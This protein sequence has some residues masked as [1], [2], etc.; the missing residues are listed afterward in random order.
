MPKVAR[1]KKPSVRVSPMMEGIKWKGRGKH[2]CVLN[3]GVSCTG[4]H[5]ALQRA[6]WPKW[7]F[8]KAKANGTLAELPLPAPDKFIP[9]PPQA[10]DRKLPYSKMQGIRYDA[11]ITKTVKLSRRHGLP[12]VFW[13][14]QANRTLV[15][16]KLKGVTKSAMATQAR[17]RN[18]VKLLMPET[19]AFWSLMHHSKMVPI[20]TQTP[21]ACNKVGTKLDVLCTL[22]EQR[23]TYRVLEMKHGCEHN[24]SIRGLESLPLSIRG[25]ERRVTTHGQHLLQTWTNHV[26]FKAAFPERKTVDPWL[27]RVDRMGAHVYVAPEQAGVLMLL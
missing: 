7:D 20:E 19:L 16:N 6:Y 26:L 22:A 15:L 3:A 24:W 1:A 25:P 21:V 5:P 23:E 11:E 13:F 2:K 9:V 17:L 27:V 18:A 4:V 14:D 8:D 12:A 10:R